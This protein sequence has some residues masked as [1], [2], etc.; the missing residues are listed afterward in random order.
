MLYPSTKPCWL[1]YA[2]LF[3]SSFGTLYA[4]LIPW[5]HLIINFS[6]S[7][8]TS[9]LCFN[10]NWKH[11][12]NI[13]FYITS[14]LTHFCGK[15]ISLFHIKHIKEHHSILRC[16]YSTLLFFNLSIFQLWLLRL[17]ILASSVRQAPVDHC[18]SLSFF[19]PPSIVSVAFLLWQ[20][21]KVME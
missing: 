9:Y 4:R 12:S 6:F 21:A 10:L 20:D 13:H 11:R 8:G 14:L 3:F 19:L 2:S 5:L 1:Y 17:L 18:I 16:F 7:S 15:L